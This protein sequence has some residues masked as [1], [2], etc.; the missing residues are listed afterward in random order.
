M[1]MFFFLFQIAR[2][3]LLASM[4]TCACATPVPRHARA[5]GHEFTQLFRATE[6]VFGTARPKD[7]VSGQGRWGGCH[8]KVHATSS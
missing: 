5:Q 7:S 3:K 2:M 8:Q 6:P 4:S 1:W